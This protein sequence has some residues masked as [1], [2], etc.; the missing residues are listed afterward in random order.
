MYTLSF[1]CFFLCMIQYH[2]HIVIFLFLALPKSCTPF[3]LFL[4]CFCVIHLHV[5]IAIFLFCLIQL[6]AHVVIFLCLAL[7]HSTPGTDCHFPISCFECFNF[8][9]TL[10]LSCFML[11]PD[12]I[13]CTHCY[14]LNTIFTKLAS[15]THSYLIIPYPYI[16]SLLFLALSI[17]RHVNIVFFFLLFPGFAWFNFMWTLLFSCFLLC[18]IYLHVHIVISCFLGLIDL[19]SYTH[20]HFLVSL[21]AW[22]SFMYILSSL[23]F[24]TLPVFSFMYTLSVSSFW[25][26]PDSTSCIHFFLF[27]LAVPKSMSWTDCHV[28]CF[29]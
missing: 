25:A 14:F 26:Q 6:H 4:S 18:L 29:L 2:V 1:S 3:H 8:V 7:H 13:S 17:Q 24:I 21:F 27:C 22:F 9:Y 19:T 10:S 23:C 12:L 5:H 16:V 15:C 28:F 20:S 11:L